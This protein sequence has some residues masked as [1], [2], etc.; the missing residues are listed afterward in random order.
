MAGSLVTET[1]STVTGLLPATSYSFKVSAVYPHDAQLRAG[2][3]GPVTA[4]TAPA[5]VPT[6]LTASIVGRGVV[7]LSWDRLVG[8]DGFRIS[9]TDAT[10]L[11]IRPMNYAGGTT[12]ATSAIDSVTVPGTHTYQIRSVYRA[13]GSSKPPLEVLSE[14]SQPVSV[15]I[16][17]SSRVRYCQSRWG[18]ARCAPPEIH[19]VTLA[20]GGL[21]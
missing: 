11:D 5:P 12:L 13:P 21:P 10:A 3:S 15:V 8:A 16:P 4:S 17:A 19:P 7:S 20:T 14:P 2:L 9:R 18:A 6:G 1:S